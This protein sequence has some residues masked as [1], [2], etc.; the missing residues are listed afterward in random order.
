MIG[1]GIPSNFDFSKV[2]QPSYSGYGTD[3]GAFFPGSVFFHGNFTSIEA[4]AVPEPS[5]GFLSGSILFGLA[6][7]KCGLRR[8]M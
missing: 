5:T 1:D 8:A 2:V 6:V 7:A 4:A 3:A